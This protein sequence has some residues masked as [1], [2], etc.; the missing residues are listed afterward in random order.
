MKPAPWCYI[1]SW[2]CIGCGICCI[3]YTVQLTLK[4]WLDIARTYGQGFIRQSLD[5]FYINKAINGPCPF[6]YRSYRRSFCVLQNK[7]PLACKLWPF[8]VC[9]VPRYGNS[10]QASFDFRGK[11][12]Y[13]YVD[14]HCNGLTYG[15]SKEIQMRKIIPEFIELSLGL[16]C[17]QAY[18][19][20][21]LTLNHI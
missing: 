2:S 21:R 12:F 15:S 4:E 10:S 20:S 7:K 8:K 1:E 19:T 3:L 17:K 13:I 18:S 11:R 6:L 5:G 16:T 14:P 9:S